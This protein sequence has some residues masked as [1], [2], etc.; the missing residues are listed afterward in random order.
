MKKIISFI[1]A[2]FLLNSGFQI[3]AQNF[4]WAKSVGAAGEQSCMDM[5]VDHQGNLYLIGNLSGANVDFDPGEGSALLSSSVGTDIFFAKYDSLG[6]Y[7]WAKSIGST[8]D[9]VGARIA[10]DDEGNVYI[11]GWFESVNVDFD[12]GPGGM[13][14]ETA[15][16]P[17]RSPPTRRPAERSLSSHLHLPES[18]GSH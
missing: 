13:V 10:V 9:D 17:F 7:L 12:P 18:A 5:A 15:G 3:Y 1:A 8:S 6:N 4:Q 14:R 16:D 11:T 2:T